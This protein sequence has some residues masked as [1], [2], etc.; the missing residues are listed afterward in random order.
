MSIDEVL[1]ITGIIYQL[2][3]VFYQSIKALHRL[4]IKF[5]ISC[6]EI[7]NDLIKTISYLVDYC[8]SNQEY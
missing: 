2:N 3:S 6:N 4:H 5:V 7:R 1:L 8:E